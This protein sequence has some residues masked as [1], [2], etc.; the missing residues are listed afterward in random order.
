MLDLF[1]LQCISHRDVRGKSVSFVNW[2]W[3]LQSQSKT[4]KRWAFVVITQ[5]FKHFII[6]IYYYI[7][8][9]LN[10]NLLKPEIWPLNRSRL[11]PYFVMIAM[12]LYNLFIILVSFGE[13]LQT[14]LVSMLLLGQLQFL[15]H[16]Q[17]LRLV[18]QQVSSGRWS[19]EYWKERLLVHSFSVSQKIMLCPQIFSYSFSFTFFLCGERFFCH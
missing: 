10:M 7:N 5:R 6:W 19:Q 1:P 13:Y 2:E 14:E 3:S 18:S 8:Y 11:F 12:V 17:F 16:S 15:Q 9:L 4:R